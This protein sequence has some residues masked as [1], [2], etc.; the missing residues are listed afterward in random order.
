MIQL[1]FVSQELNCNMLNVC[2]VFKLSLASSSEL[3]LNIPFQSIAVFQ[4]QFLVEQGG[5]REVK[6]LSFIR[7]QFPKNTDI[8]LRTLVKRC[9]NGPVGKD[10]PQPSSLNVSTHFIKKER[11]ESGKLY[12][13]FL[14]NSIMCSYPH[15]QICHTD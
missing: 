8:T 15:T 13:D 2:E 7:R 14:K 5:I 6:E 12:A 10:M 4:S 9:E 11:D 3:V 1:Y